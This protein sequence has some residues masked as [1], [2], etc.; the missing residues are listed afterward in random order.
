MVFAKVGSLVS[1]I[2]GTAAGTVGAVA[3]GAAAINVGLGICVT[4]CGFLV[5]QKTYDF[6][7][8]QKQVRA[9]CQTC[10]NK[11]GS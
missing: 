11:A 6:F 2:A 5:A 7:I 3:F 4:G 9:P 8:P 10:V 1:S